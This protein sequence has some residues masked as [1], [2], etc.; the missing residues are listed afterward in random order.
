MH[1]SKVHLSV[2]ALMLLVGVGSAQAANSTV[3]GPN[4]A[5]SVAVWFLGPGVPSCCV[6]LTNMY[7]STSTATITNN[8]GDPNPAIQW[9]TDTPT[10]LEITPGGLSALLTALAPSTHKTYD[11][12]VWAIVDGVPTNKLPVYINTPVSISYSNPVPLNGGR[13]SCQALGYPS[14]WL[15]YVEYVTN[16]IIDLT[17]TLT[18]TKIDVNETIENEKDIPNGNWMLPTAGVWPAFTGWN[19][20]TT[21]LDYLSSCGTGTG[22]VPELVNYNPGASAPAMSDT[23]KFWV[24]TRTH[25][26]GECVEIDDTQFNSGFATQTQQTTPGSTPQQQ[27]AACAQGHTILN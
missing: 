20:N 1:F 21:F 24:G 19:T 10:S 16:S 9:V 11:I 6:G 15:G 23:Q 2:V 7:Y 5:S 25:F 13:G 22:L 26:S 8:S 3:A 12:N 4:G 18:L 27:T 14:N 17:G